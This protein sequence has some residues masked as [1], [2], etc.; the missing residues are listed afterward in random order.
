MTDVPDFA[1]GETTL[2]SITGIDLSA[3]STRDITMQ[4]EYIAQAAQVDRDINGSLIDLSEPQFRKY[5]VTI[6]CTDVESPVLVGVHPGLP[7]TVVC[8]PQLGLNK[9]T[10]DEQEVLTLSCLVMP[11]SVS[12]QEYAG[13]TGWQIVA[14]E[15]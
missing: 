7:I 1:N 5:R 15:V 3:Y 13:R 10:E 11:W 4:L 8:I 6:T 9:N 2:L 14:E 12:R